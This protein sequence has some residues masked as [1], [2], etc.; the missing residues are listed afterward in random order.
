MCKWTH[1][2]L[3]IQTDIFVF[4]YGSISKQNK[5]K[6][7][8]IVSK[9][10]WHRDMVNIARKPNG[11]IT[12]YGNRKG[13]FLIF[14]SIVDEN[15]KFATICIWSKNQLFLIK[16]SNL[17]SDN[18]NFS[19]KTNLKKKSNLTKMSN[20]MKMS[21]LRKKSNLQKSQN[22]EKCQIINVAST[23]P[24]SSHS[25]HLVSHF[26]WT[27]R[28][29]VKSKGNRLDFGKVT[30]VIWLLSWKH[31]QLQGETFHS[32]HKEDESGWM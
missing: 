18:W 32:I 14:L 10:D 9:V 3:L 16:I 26:C 31:E 6:T 27:E 24:T 5:H 30:I 19:K 13:W 8:V 20:L 21:N 22:W 29:F 28:K 17:K 15:I 1:Y 12:L 23:S 4:E 11:K 7:W 25:L 2:V